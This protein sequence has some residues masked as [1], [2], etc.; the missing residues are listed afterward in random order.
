MKFPDKI[1]EKGYFFLFAWISLGE[2][3][4]LLTAR[5][6]PFTYYHTLQAF[7]PPA[8]IF[9]HLAVIRSLLTIICLAPLFNYAFNRERNWAWFFKPLLY[10]RI[11]ADLAGHNYEWQFLKTLFHTTPLMPLAALS[12]WVGMT[13]LSYKAHFLCA[14]KPQP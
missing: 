6:E 10:V 12:V 13:F 9:Y 7:Y 11:F 8:G 5:S 2:L 4:A 1:F 3:S 14:Y